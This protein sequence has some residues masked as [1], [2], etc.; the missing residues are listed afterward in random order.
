LC[1]YKFLEQ[2]NEQTRDNLS[3]LLEKLFEEIVKEKHNTFIGKH[4]V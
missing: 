1:D 2:T 3:K 4:V